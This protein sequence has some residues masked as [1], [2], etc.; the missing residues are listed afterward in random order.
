MTPVAATSPVVR[1][2]RQVT[3]VNLAVRTMHLVTFR[4]VAALTMRQNL[5][6]VNAWNRKLPLPPLLPLQQQRLRL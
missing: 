3:S 4:M 6:F 1:T 5:P 2:T